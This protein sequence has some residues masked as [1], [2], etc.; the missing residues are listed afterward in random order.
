MRERAH[1]GSRK[2]GDSIEVFPLDLFELVE[3]DD[4]IWPPSHRLRENTA[5]LLSHE[6]AVGGAQE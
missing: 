1:A 5:F 2:V 3:E 4:L 6:T